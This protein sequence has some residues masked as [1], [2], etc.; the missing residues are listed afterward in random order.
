MPLQKSDCQFSF[1]SFNTISLLSIKEK[2]IKP[3]YQLISN[4]FYG[5]YLSSRKQD[6]FLNEIQ[7]MSCHVSE[8]T[9]V[10]Q[11][12]MILNLIVIGC[13][14]TLFNWQTLKYLPVNMIQLCNI[15]IS[16]KLTVNIFQKSL[17]ELLLQD[18]TILNDIHLL[19]MRL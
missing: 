10:Y 19:K 5:Y 12:I 4:Q 14:V 8:I 6:Y 1:S 18:C 9:K 13:F 16:F 15:S 3:N 7:Q 11:I 17:Q 2:F